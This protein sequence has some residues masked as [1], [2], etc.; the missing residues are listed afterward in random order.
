MNKLCLKI[1]E[2]KNDLTVEVGG[3]ENVTVLRDIKVVDGDLVEAL[4]NLPRGSVHGDCIQFDPLKFC[5][6]QNIVN[7]FSKTC[8]VH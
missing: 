6:Q 4:Q 2:T 5:A 7:G 1:S 3:Y 8:Y